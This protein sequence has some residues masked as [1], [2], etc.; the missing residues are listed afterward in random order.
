MA[1]LNGQYL[2]VESES[3]ERGVDVTSHPVESGIDITDNVRR[4]AIT[5]SVS[6]KIVRAG[7]SVKSRVHKTVKYLTTTPI[8]TQ[9]DRM[10]TQAESQRQRQEERLLF[11]EKSVKHKAILAM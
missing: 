1:L 8:I 5:I 11:T 2:F 10:H 4:K 9:Q 7:K 3:V 6:G